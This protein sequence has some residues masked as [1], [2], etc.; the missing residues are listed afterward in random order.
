MIVP[1]STDAPIYYF[2]WMTFFLIVVNG[3]V[4][5]ITD[6]GRQSEGWLLQYGNGLH[7]LEWL[8]YSFLHFGSMHLIG[9]MFFLWAFGIVI[10]GKLGWFVFL[11]LYL[12]IG[13]AG[14][15]L[16]QVAMLGHLNAP[17]RDVA[18]ELSGESSVVTPAFVQTVIGDQGADPDTPSAI[19]IPGIPE[20]KIPPFDNNEIDSGDLKKYLRAHSG[21]GGASLVVFALL[22]IVLVWAPKNEVSCFCLLG[23]HVVTFELEYLYFCGFK[24]ALE[25]LG[26]FF[27]LQG[28]EVTSEVAH[29][30][31]AILGVLGATL[32][33]KFKWVDCEN[34]DL[35]A[36]LQNRHGNLARVGD[37][38]GLAI[39]SNGDHEKNTPRPQVHQDEVSQERTRRPKKKKVK[40]HLIA[41]D[42][43]DEE[44]ED[45][46]A[47]G[48]PVITP[49]EKAESA[50]VA[51]T[52]VARGQPTL[53]FIPPV[54]AKSTRSASAHELIY[55]ALHEGR[56]AEAYSEF[57]LQ[58]SL[59]SLFE[60]PQDHLSGL[61]D[62]FLKAHDVE[63]ARPL[64]VEYIRR[65]PQNADRHRLKLAM[66]LVTPL[67]RPGA[68]LKLLVT[69]NQSSLSDN[70]QKLYAQVARQ[71]QKMVSEGV[72]D[73]TDASWNDA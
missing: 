53:P 63:T 27:R 38:P 15:L 36:Y 61:A 51:Q 55:S 39:F 62:G 25:F 21:E 6:M 37:W 26:A 54:A 29:A 48:R 34:W 7:P 49:K 68:A 24:I 59:N 12:G 65:F 60:L 73:Q 33:L 20:L 1:Y 11:S 22:G 47:E 50:P 45:A 18:A 43:F 42:S 56:L 46:V 71:A 35:F 72:V 4:F 32:F 67:T 64:L 40:E 9:N 17:A 2:P 13:V 19:H 28:F 14:G 52:P 57:L 23:F 41:L 3:I 31:G 10:E 44:F 70:Y 30:L 69:I 5:A 66:V 16:I 58:R 8:A